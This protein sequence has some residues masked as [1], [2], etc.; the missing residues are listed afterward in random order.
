MNTPKT[1]TI[2]AAGAMG[3]SAFAAS[4]GYG[5]GKKAGN[6]AQTNPKPESSTSLQ[7]FIPEASDWEPIFSA[8][9]DLVGRYHPQRGFQ[10]RDPRSF[11]EAWQRWANG[12]Q[13]KQHAM[14]KQGSQISRKAD[15]EQQYVRGDI[16]TEGIDADARVP[17]EAREKYPGAGVPPGQR[18]VPA[19]RAG[20]QSAESPDWGMKLFDAE[21]EPVGHYSGQDFVPMR[22]SDLLEKTVARQL[23]GAESGMK[24]SGKSSAGKKDSG[25]HGNPQKQQNY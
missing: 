17:S 24:Q 3:L 7:A 6:P 9:G 25:K 20:E 11:Q 15:R 23:G 12:G 4:A 5:P 14:K 10:A 2:I 16:G 13:A 21:G 1:I 19:G 8:E 18:G 22:D